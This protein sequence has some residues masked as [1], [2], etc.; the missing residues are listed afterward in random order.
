MD[1]E[2]N[3]IVMKKLLKRFPILIF[4][5]LLLGAF[6]QGAAPAEGARLQPALAEL[7]SE[8]PE[9]SVRVMVGARGERAELAGLV[10]SLGGRV[11][12]DLHILNALAAE[13]PAGAAADLAQHASV[14]WLS[15]DG[16]VVS[17]GK[18][19]NGGGGSGGGGGGTS[20]TTETLRD[21]FNTVSY[22]NNDG[23]MPWSTGWI[24]TGDYNG[25][26]GG[27]VTVEVDII[28]PVL[29]NRCVEFDG[30]TG[31]NS[32]LE[33]EMDLSGVTSATLTFDYKLDH[34]SAEYTLD[35]SSD[36]GAAW[37]TLRT[38]SNAINS[39]D[40]VDLTPYASAST[41]IR[42]RL[43]GPEEDAH[44][45]ID[46]ILVTYQT[47]SSGGGSSLPPNFY[48]DTLDVRDV[49]DMGYTGA[50]I[51]VA[52]IDSGVSQDHDFSNFGARL[53]FNPNSNTVNDVF[54]HGTHVAG[55]IAGD[56]VNS[57]GFYQGVAPDANLISLKISDE[58]GM[59][60]ESDTVDAMQ[61][62]LDNKDT[63]NI[64]VVNLSIQSGTEVSYHLSPMAAA[65]EILW[66]NGVVVVAATGNWDGGPVYPLNA[67]PAND[68]FVITVGATDEKGT[69]RRN[70]DSWMTSSAVGVTQDGFAKPEIMAP[71]KDII[72]VL[73]NHSPWANQHPDRVVNVGNS[74][75][76]FRI[77]GT[78]MATPMVS[79]AVALLLQAEPNLTPDQ[80]KYRV[81]NATYWV[82]GMPYLNIEKMLTTSTTGSANTGIQASQLLWT[83]NDPVT[84]NS[85]NWNSVNWNSVNWN[86]VNWNSV[87]WNSVNWNSLDWTE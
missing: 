53:S 18:G 25:P 21:D 70:D 41:R 11:V 69:A 57:S 36:G 85:V 49:W 67:P 38:Y 60:Y 55:I 19:G 71:G 40:S 12:K 42:F 82:S 43:S 24:E 59:A 10:E 87:N 23:S 3:A 51:G 54:G 52:V 63:F 68:P 28:C 30:D 9:E 75:Q 37:T 26:S 64:R 8:S 32:T 81:T 78:S 39:S 50:G 65:A 86:S 31:L 14:T 84:W 5:A 83:G 76:Y 47:T 34:S 33:R 35:V 2:I 72:S 79:G 46:N 73:S 6:G 77:S 61:W 22:V 13:M 62:V 45:G 15:L 74:A 4:L 27:N 48:L 20:T 56:G 29:L 44:L 1:F 16:P 7:A 66:F 80:V 58:T 17:T